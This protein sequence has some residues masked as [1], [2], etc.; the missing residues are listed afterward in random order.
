MIDFG[1]T[2]VGREASSE[3]EGFGERRLRRHVAEPCK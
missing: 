1:Q 3:W 2:G